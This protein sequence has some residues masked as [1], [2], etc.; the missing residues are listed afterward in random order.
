VN[1]ITATLEPEN[2]RFV[3]CYF[4]SWERKFQDEQVPVML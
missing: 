4:R 2:F 1:A 3:P